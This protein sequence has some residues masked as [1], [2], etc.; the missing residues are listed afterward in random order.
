M[1]ICVFG[2]VYTSYIRY[3]DCVLSAEAL[4]LNGM[5][6]LTSTKPFPAKFPPWLRRETTRL[7]GPEGVRLAPATVLPTPPLTQVCPS[8]FDQSDPRLPCSVY[9]LSAHSSVQ[10]CFYWLACSISPSVD[11]SDPYLPCSVYTSHLPF[12]L[13]SHLFSHAFTG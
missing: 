3:I 10:S 12:H 11:Q 5:W 13:F 9:N 2:V 4:R 6:A 1:S 7:T 8:F